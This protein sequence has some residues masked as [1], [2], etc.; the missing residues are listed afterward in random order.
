[1]PLSRL[2]FAAT[3]LWLGTTLVVVGL[4]PAPYYNIGSYITIIGG[5]AVMGLSLVI[6]ARR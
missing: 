2:L 1:M 4:T 6:A 3:I 5:L